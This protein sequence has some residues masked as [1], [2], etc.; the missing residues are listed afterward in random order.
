M[1]GTFKKLTYTI[2]AALVAALC[3]LILCESGGA[4]YASA[5]SEYSK[6]VTAYENRNVGT[7]YRV[8]ATTGKALI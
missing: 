8:Q 1:A 3:F 2:A 5:A 4:G 6:I 7:I